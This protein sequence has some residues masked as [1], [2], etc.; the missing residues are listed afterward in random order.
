MNRRE[1]IA[2]LGGAA[3]ACS[4][5]AR[6]QQQPIQARRV[7]VLM[8]GPAT[9]AMSQAYVGAFAQALRQL[10]WI[11][12]QNLRIDIRWNAGD[13][14]LAQTYAAQLLGIG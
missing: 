10:G 13:A 5:M 9:D 3:V 14:A 11:E 7:G 1:V 12:G 4:P 6:A 8:G 2:L